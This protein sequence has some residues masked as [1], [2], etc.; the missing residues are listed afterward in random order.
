MHCLNLIA[1]DIVNVGVHV[2]HKD[3]VLTKEELCVLSLGT[4]FVP[5]SRKH[6]RNI[7]S[8]ALSK[9]IRSVR[10]KKHFA[11]SDYENTNTS[12]PESILHTR[13]NKT[14]TLEEAYKQ[15]NPKITKSPIENY[16]TEVKT[17]VQTEGERVQVIHHLERK[18]WTYFYDTVS[19]LK[20]RTDII[21]KP[22]D[23]NL[24]VA[25][26]RRDWYIKEALGTTYLGNP[27]TYQAV[28]QQPPLEP[29]ITKLRAICDSQTWL[30]QP[31]IHK[32]LED[33]TSDYTRDRVKLCRMY[34]LP[35]L[36]KPTLALRPICAS[37]GWITYW[38]SVYIHL[39]I[40]PLL[41]RIP[42]YL[43]NS[44]QLVTLIEQLK[45]PKEFIFLEADVDNLYPSIN[46]NDGVQALFTFLHSVSDFP[47]SRIVFLLKL[48]LW[49]LTNNYVS[50]G[51][52]TFLQI[53][54]TAMGTPCAVI[55]ACIYMHVLEQEAWKQFKVMHQ[56]NDSIFL[57]FRWLDDI[58]AIVTNRE[59][60]LALMELLNSRRPSIKLTF[61]LHNQEATF[62][63]LTLYK[64]AKG[65][66]IAV[67]AY[68]KPNNKFLFLPPT[69]C[70]PKHIFQGWITGYGRRLRT[71]CTETS[72]FNKCLDQF[73]RRLLARGYTSNVIETAFTAIPT[74]E[75]IFREL[76]QQTKQNQTPKKIGIPF[77]VTYS[78]TIREAL[79]RLRQA[80][81]LTEE[82]FM[83]PHL[84][85][86]F[87]KRT[88]PL[89]AFKRN[90]NLKELVCP[91]ALK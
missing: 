55:F 62:L 41:K 26:L 42:T 17:H 67:K 56:R 72:D 22:A 14:L 27:N 30:P 29:I 35:K 65:D 87:G 53:T 28:E 33:F 46:I 77:V 10:L 69:S 60:G 38:T 12:T 90:S 84:P 24:G 40:F 76:R 89:I 25:V 8:D 32:L 61:K 52:K 3:I 7:L 59:S 6:K 57:F 9:F 91:S 51:T 39:S 36:H 15:F 54:G 85:L 45:P 37:L 43:S 21:I 78:P 79:P 74:R 81:T 23:K 31:K 50:F 71:N 13:V 18:K 70:H 66:K 4:T 44:A 88:T 48:T 19:K 16:L 75:E 5:P 86:L 2:V 20:S 63:D 73:R 11:D 64:T 58:I 1:K 83:D 34:F 47:K 49:V 82:A 80:L 68:S